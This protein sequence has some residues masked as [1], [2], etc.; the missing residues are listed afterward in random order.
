MQPREAFRAT[1][2]LYHT[3]PSVYVQRPTNEQVPARLLFGEMEG[4]HAI[5]AYADEHDE[6]VVIDQCAYRSVDIRVV[7]AGNEVFRLWA[8]DAE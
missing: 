8:Y 4:S 6:A 3:W 2:S 5:K 7:L 1:T